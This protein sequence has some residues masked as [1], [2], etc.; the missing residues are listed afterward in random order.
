MPGALE[1]Y[2][3][4][5]KKIKKQTHCATSPIFADYLALKE[6]ILMW[7]VL[8]SSIGTLLEYSHNLF[9][10]VLEGF[11]PEKAFH[12]GRTIWANLLGVVLHGGE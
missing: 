1:Y 10:K 8:A 3:D 5:L 6:I 12:R 2:L 7:S 9:P 4:K 11:S